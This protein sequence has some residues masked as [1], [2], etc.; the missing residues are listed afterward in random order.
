MKVLITY[1]LSNPY[2]S[3]P[4]PINILVLTSTIIWNSNI[5]YSNTEHRQNAPQQL[6]YQ[7]HYNNDGV[8]MNN[9]LKYQR[10]KEFK[11]T[12]N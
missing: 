2:I 3:F 11:S 6:F 12:T 7:T 8:R 4:H 9:Y 10:L 5:V 1:K